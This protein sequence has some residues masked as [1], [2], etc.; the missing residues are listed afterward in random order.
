MDLAETGTWSANR[1]RGG[2]YDASEVC[3]T[4]DQFQGKISRPIRHRSAVTSM[5]SHIGCTAFS[6]EQ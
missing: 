2:G 6:I 5:P 1:T 4:S 3:E